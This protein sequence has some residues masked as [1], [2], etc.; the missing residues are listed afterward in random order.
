MR[1]LHISDIHIGANSRS[2]RV[3]KYRRHFF[4]DLRKQ[5]QKQPVNFIIFTGDL[6]NRG[7]WNKDLINEAVSFLRELYEIC[8][9]IGQWSWQK[10][11]PMSR[12]YYC[13]GNH[14]VLRE[15]YT[16]ADGT[17]LHRR[18]VLSA[19]SANGYFT[20][21]EQ[22]YSLLT[23]TSFAAFEETMSRLV[24]ENCY[25]STYPIEYKSFNL[26]PECIGQHIA[27]IGINTALLAGQE[28][29]PDIIRQELQESYTEFLQADACLDTSAALKAYERY[30]TATLKKLGHL[31]NDEKNLTFISQAARTELDGLLSNCRVPI[32][33]GHHPLSML[34]PES[35]TQ[36]E[37]FADK[38]TALIYLCGHTHRASGKAINT[39]FSNL[40]DEKGSILQITIGGIFLDDSGYNQAS[41]A[42]GQLDFSSEDPTIQLQLDIRTFSLD[43]FGKERWDAHTGIKNIQAHKVSQDFL[44]QDEAPAVHDMQELENQ[45]KRMDTIKNT[46]KDDYKKEDTSKDDLASRFKKDG[47]SGGDPYKRLQQLLNKMEDQADE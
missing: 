41:Y 25:H 34:N 9:D 2:G 16:F 12:L 30:H 17:I 18:S 37:D 32:I 20:V 6:F 23:S 3:N 40:W 28:Y 42:I 19:A 39:S 26:P 5:L 45:K 29:P 36:Y 15:A 1:W 47:E 7:V 24:S 13:P 11:G 8:S 43:I 14:D 31:A 38:N 33:F 22:N 4:E 27:V 21:N 10:D 35:Q 44:L 46:D